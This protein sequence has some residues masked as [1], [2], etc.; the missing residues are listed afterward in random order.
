MALNKVIHWFRQDLRLM[1]N[2]AFA[3]AAQ[4]GE[5]LPVYILDTQHNTKHALGA[6]S[7]CWLHHALHA[8]NLSLDQKL[9]MQAGKPEEIL[10]ALIKQHNIT[11]VF[12]NR[13]YEPWQI[14]RDEHI[15]KTLKAMGITVRS[16]NSFL[17]WEPWEVLSG[18]GTAYK[19]FTPF[20]QKG[21]LKTA[22]PRRPNV[23]RPEFSLVQSTETARK[24]DSLGLLPQIRWDIALTKHWNISEHAAQD[25]LTRF[26]S[27]S[28]ACYRTQ[29]DYPC[30]HH[31]SRLSPYLH[32]GQISPHQMWYSVEAYPADENSECFRRELAWREFSYHLL[33]YFPTLQHQ[34][35]QQKFDNFPWHDEPDILS[36]W[37]QG[38][39]GIP[40]VDA[41][42][43]ELWE[44]G[45][46]HNRVRMIV[47][48]FLVKNLLIDWRHG[49]RWFWDCLV[50]ADLANNSASW[51]WVAGCG[52]DAA[53]YF[54]VFNPV[55]QG[56]KFDPD[57]SYIRRFVPELKHVPNA[58]LFSPWEAP[59]S[60]LNTSKIV[61]GKTYPH[62]I[63][64]IKHT[65]QRALD[66]FAKL[67]E[68]N[69]AN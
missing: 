15:K 67:S 14:D 32:F 31:V 5:V 46:M 28:L 33:Y 54:R 56:Q 19:V 29:R 37:Q 11:A 16:F 22:E 42:M 1:D 69:T 52:A 36:R 20:Y 4:Q 2:P 6:A 43:R 25:N 68:S 55:T 50:D 41:G 12:W 13:C 17:L 26:L 35:F 44:T 57:G 51:Q 34:N 47:G 49:E 60:V 3:Y 8:L 53:P 21:C 63:V 10:L 9:L 58:Y 18:K 38:K 66:I 24:I 45:Y 40:I 64:D 62:P 39:T 23:S 59:E 65:R 27:Q 61:L 30:A 48:S 7:R